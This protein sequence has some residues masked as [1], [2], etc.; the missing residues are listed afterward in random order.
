MFEAVAC[1]AASFV[2]F[3]AAVRVASMSTFVA[4]RARTIVECDHP[5]IRGSELQKASQ[6]NR[7]KNAAMYRNWTGT[8]VVVC[9]D[10]EGAAN[11]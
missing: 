1:G 10:P 4:T 8:S 9:S 2:P 6:W 5:V 3:G 7:P 11:Q